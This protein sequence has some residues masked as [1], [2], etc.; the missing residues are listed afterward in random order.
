MVAALPFFFVTI[1]SCQFYNR[2][3]STSLGKAF[4]I[5]AAEFLGNS[6]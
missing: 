6:V 4:L 2:F 5:K 1:V 3:Y